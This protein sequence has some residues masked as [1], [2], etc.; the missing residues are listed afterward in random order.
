[1]PSHCSWLVAGFIWHGYYLKQIGLGLF[2]VGWVLQ[3]VGHAF[4]HTWPEFF[5]DPRF[6]LVGLRW[7]FAKM[8]GKA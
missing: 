2:I 3:F 5:H 4:E 6:L 8:K 7:W 1:L